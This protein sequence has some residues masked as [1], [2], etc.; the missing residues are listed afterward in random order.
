[1]AEVPSLNSAPDSAPNIGIG[2]L[3]V[4]IADDDHDAV[5]TLMTILRHEGYE[6]RGVYKGNDVLQAAKDFAPDAVLL[7]ITMPG[8]SGYDAARALREGYGE[9]LVLIAI[10]AWWKQSSDILLARMV[11]FNHHFGKPYEAQAIIEVLSRVK[12]KHD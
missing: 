9:K 7:D 5:L 10:T 1:M 2:P 8:M 6:V 11:G 12:P 4:L 3:R